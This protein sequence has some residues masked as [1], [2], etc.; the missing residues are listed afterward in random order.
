MRFFCHHLIVLIG[1]IVY[2]SGVTVAVFTVV[3]MVAF[4]RLTK[5][6]SLLILRLHIRN[7]KK[8]HLTSSMNGSYYTYCILGM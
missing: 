6:S 5:K 8:L 2:E 3:V 4:D 1:Y 7:T